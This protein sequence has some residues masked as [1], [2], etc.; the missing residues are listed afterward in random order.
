MRRLSG[1]SLMEMMVVLL[2]VAIIAAASAPMVNKKLLQNMAD[3]SSPWVWLGTKNDIG[4]N[5]QNKTQSV[6]F[7]VSFD[8]SIDYSCKI[9]K[10][11]GVL[12]GRFDIPHRFV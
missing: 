6:P 3:M 10:R 4:F 2:I 9:M 7:F 8:D 12:P 5:I 1:F 11:V